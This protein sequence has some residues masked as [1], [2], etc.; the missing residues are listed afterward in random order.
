MLSKF[1]AEANEKKTT[2]TVVSPTKFSPYKPSPVKSPSVTIIKLLCLLEPRESE[3]GSVKE[4]LTD[5]TPQE[6]E[7][8]TL[9]WEYFR[10]N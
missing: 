10:L 2:Q 3:D 5:Y 1:C 8:L 9:D 6:I 4:K 7:N